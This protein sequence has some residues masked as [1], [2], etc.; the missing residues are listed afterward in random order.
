MVDCKRLNGAEDQ[1]LAAFAR[2]QL[3]EVLSTGEQDYR[4][5]IYDAGGNAH[6]LCLPTTALELFSDALAIMA[7][8]D[9]VALGQIGSEL[10]TQEA[11]DLLGM[12]RPT[13]I[14]LLDAD[15]LPHTRKG[16]RRKVSI[17]DVLAYKK[18][19]AD[20]RLDALGQLSSLDQELGLGY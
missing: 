11:A 17:E 19:N 3:G 7:K 10:T 4:V 20:G 15:A 13:F 16:N 8:G 6:E 12:S 1:Q 14:K 18:K 9:A 2:K 5:R